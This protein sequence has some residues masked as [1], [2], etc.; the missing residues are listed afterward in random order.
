MT[1]AVVDPDAATLTVPPAVG[2]PVVDA[3]SSTPA[4]GQDHEAM[5]EISPPF[6][7]A[8]TAVAA[9]VV[10]WVCDGAYWEGEHRNAPEIR[11]TSA[12]PSPDGAM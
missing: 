6:D 5:A 10:S 12:P 1:T 7:P 2:H 11:L 3:T 8:A 9:A 4:D